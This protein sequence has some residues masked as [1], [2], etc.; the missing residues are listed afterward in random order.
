[1]DSLDKETLRRM[2]EMERMMPTSEQRRVM[3]EMQRIARDP[4]LRLAKEQARIASEAMQGVWG[5]QNEYLRNEIHNVAIS[6]GPLL[7]DTLYPQLQEFFKSSTFETIRQEQLRIVR[8]SIINFQQNLWPDIIESIQATA[9]IYD[10]PYRLALETF[11]HLNIQR[12]PELEAIIDTTLKK[13]KSRPLNKKSLTRIKRK[14]LSKKRLAHLTPEEKFWLTTGIALLGLLVALYSAVQAG[15]PLQ[16]D[17]NQLEQ[18]LQPAVTYNF[19]IVSNTKPVKY[20]VDR[21]CT[22][23][24]K[25]VFK[26]PSVIKLSEGDIVELIESSHKWIHVRIN[27]KE[28]WANKKYFERITDE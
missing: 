2:R 5:K 8:D 1:M 16:I 14:A 6:L 15:K 10:S 7:A 24:T 12:S 23:T 25:P 22:V 3:E 26:A 13:A 19:N 21:P 11:Q 18:F 20:R 27:D 9:R 17:P 28:G 4:M